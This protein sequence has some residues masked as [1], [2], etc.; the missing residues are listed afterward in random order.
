MDPALHDV[1]LAMNRD[2]VVDI[3]TD[4]PGAQVRQDGVAFRAHVK[5]VLVVDVAAAGPEKTLEPLT[6]ADSSTY[7]N[8]FTMGGAGPFEVTVTFRR[9]GTQRGIQARFQYARQ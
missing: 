1:R 9:P 5:D 6:L 4:A 8:Y 7:G 3:C 2:R